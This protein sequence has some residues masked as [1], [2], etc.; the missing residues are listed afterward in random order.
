VSL[1]TE[2]A[3]TMYRFARSL[4]RCG[5]ISFPSQ[6]AFPCWALAFQRYRSYWCTSVF[7]NTSSAIGASWRALLWFREHRSREETLDEAR[8][9]MT[10]M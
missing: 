7:C 5:G 3:L 1:R 9:N 6:S 10:V 8:G 4:L 2:L